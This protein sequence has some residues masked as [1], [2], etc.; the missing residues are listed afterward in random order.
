MNKCYTWKHKRSGNWQTARTEAVQGSDQTE[1]KHDNTKGNAKAKAK[2]KAEVRP[3]GQPIEERIEA[4]VETAAAQ[5][6]FNGTMTT[7]MKVHGQNAVVLLDTGT[8]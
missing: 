4:V 3:E 6:N 2:A 8:T 5:R 7:L 1:S